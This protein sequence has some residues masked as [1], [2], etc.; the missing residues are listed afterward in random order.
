MLRPMTDATWI[1]EAVARRQ[2]V[3]DGPGDLSERWLLEGNRVAL[4]EESGPHLDEE[5]CVRLEAALRTNFVR[6]LIVISNDPLVDEDMVYELSISAEDLAAFSWEFMSIN[7]LLLPHS[8]TELAVLFS[9]DDY[10]LV[11]GTRQFVTDYAGDLK[12]ARDDFA[13]DP[14]W[15]MTPLLREV[16]RYMSW[17]DDHANA[18]RHMRLFRRI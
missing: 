11:A 16:T 15:V 5:Q 17:I 12:A 8:G 1:R 13:E 3:A 7:A 10:H 18:T 4:A 9:T 6:Q 2:L 14:H